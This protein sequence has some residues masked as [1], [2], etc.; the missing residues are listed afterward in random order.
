M[1]GHAGKR[2]HFK[3]IPAAKISVGRISEGHRC[4]WVV[5]RTI[6]WK[7][8]KAWVHKEAQWVKGTYCQVWE[9]KFNSRDSNGARRFFCSPWLYPPTNL[10]TPK[11]T[12]RH[13]Q[14]NTEKKS[15]IKKW[16][17]KKKSNYQKLKHLRA[18]ACNYWNYSFTQ[19]GFVMWCDSL[20]WYSG[21]QSLEL[22]RTWRHSSQMFSLWGI[23]SGR[24][25]NSY[26]LLG[27]NSDRNTG[28]E[29]SVFL[30]FKTYSQMLMSVN[31][32][33]VNVSKLHR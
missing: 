14:I 9:P 32:N 23:F 26:Y 17:L 5:F 16:K 24:H 11:D 33:F 12:H 22:I 8:K 31:L 18:K 28:Y 21:C 19:L 20:I 25:A 30:M 1:G 27:L 29:F 10:P 15:V 7:S 4:G 13:T 3:F 2:N 6:Y